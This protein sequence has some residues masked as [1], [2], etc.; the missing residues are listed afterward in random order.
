MLMEFIEVL[1]VWYEEVK[2]SE[3]PTLLKSYANLRKMQFNF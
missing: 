2:G 1:L 3:M